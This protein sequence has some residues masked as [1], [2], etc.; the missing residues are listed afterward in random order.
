MQEEWNSVYITKRQAN[1]SL[2][3]YG[4]KD[5]NFIRFH[6][7]ASEETVAGSDYTGLTGGSRV[8][9]HQLFTTILHQEHSHW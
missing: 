5:F 6:Y 1:F 3:Q 2:K 7:A 4:L 8:S 9:K